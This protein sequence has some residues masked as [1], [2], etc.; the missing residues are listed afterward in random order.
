MVQNNAIAMVNTPSLY[1]PGPVV[2]RY[3]GNGDIL[4]ICFRNALAAAIAPIGIGVPAA[5]LAALPGAIG[6]APAAALIAGPAPGTRI[7]ISFPYSGNRLGWSNQLFSE[8]I[9]NLIN[10]RFFDPGTPPAIRAANCARVSGIN[11]IVRR[12]P[13]KDIPNITDAITAAAE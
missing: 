11:I 1:V 7:S 10:D 12:H 2:A 5:I 3:P 13:R 8:I 9:L 6:A 4:H